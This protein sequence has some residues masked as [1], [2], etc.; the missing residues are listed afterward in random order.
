MLLAGVSVDI[1]CFVKPAAESCNGAAFEDRFSFFAEVPKLAPGTFS[2][3]AEIGIREAFGNH[4][5]LCGAVSGFRQLLLSP[6][7]YTTGVPFA[8]R[9][10]ACEELRELSSAGVQQIV[11]RLNEKEARRLDLDCVRNLV[12][13]CQAAG[14]VLW[15]QFELH[16]TFSED[17]LRIARMVEDRQFTVTVLPVRVRPTRRMALHE[18][19]PLQA[20]ERVQLL[21]KAAGEVALRRTTQ[22]EVIEICVGNAQDRPLGELIAAVRA[23]G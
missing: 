19:L 13:A 22:N 2:F 10:R 20:G 1:H 23:R 14:T 8:D 3:A 5:A 11:L 7:L 17:C 12:E 15:L 16:D 21:L 6:R 18:A 9:E 4:A